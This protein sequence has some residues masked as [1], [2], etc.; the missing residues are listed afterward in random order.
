M[1]NHKIICKLSI[2]N[3][4]K[5]ILTAHKNIV[6]LQLTFFAFKKQNINIQ[7]DYHPSLVLWYPNLRPSQTI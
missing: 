1:F 6:N 5:L 7:D 4:V 3:F 2:T